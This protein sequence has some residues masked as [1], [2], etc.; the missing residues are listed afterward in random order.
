MTFAISCLIRPHI[1]APNSGFFG[2]GYLSFARPTLDDT[3][4]KSNKFKH[5]FGYNTVCNGCKRFFLCG[6]FSGSAVLTVEAKNDS[7]QPSLP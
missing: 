2:V 6:V 1:L 4:T 7:N 5:K 3:V